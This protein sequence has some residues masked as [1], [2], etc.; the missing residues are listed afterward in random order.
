MPETSTPS[1]PAGRS[2]PRPGL[3]DLMILI[4]AVAVPF[5]I[6]RR[7]GAFGDEGWIRTAHNGAVWLMASLAFA[8]MIIAA[9][10]KVVRFRRLA[11]QPGFA[12]CVAIATSLVVAVV[13]E[14]VHEFNRLKESKDGAYP[15]LSK[16]T[17][18]QSTLYDSLSETM[19]AAIASVWLT[20]L[21]SGRWRF[22]NDAIERLSLGI[23]VYALTWKVLDYF[24]PEYNWY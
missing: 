16:V 14:A 18:A 22:R 1:H 10:K 2:R 12:A 11:T 20:I 23:G 21:M 4:A 24:L 15:A 19:P 6:K 7:I 17:I 8:L 3:A 5:A 9:R 13:T